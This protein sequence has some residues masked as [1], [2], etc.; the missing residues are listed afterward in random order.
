MNLNIIL[1]GSSPL[2]CYIQ[3]AYM[4]GE[5]ENLDVVDVDLSE[6]DIIP[7]PDKI[8]FVVTKGN[9]EI[10]QKS[11]LPFAENIQS[12]LE[13]K[14]LLSPNCCGENQPGNT[15]VDVLQLTDGRDAEKIRKQVQKKIEEIGK[16][17]TINHIAINNTGGTKTMSIYATLAVHNLCVNNSIDITEVYVDP[18][19]DKLR[20][21]VMKNRKAFEESMRSFPREI[22]KDLRNCVKLSIEE[23]VKLHFGMKCKITRDLKMNKAYDELKD[24]Y[25]KIYKEIAKRILADSKNIKE[26]EDEF[27]RILTC[28]KTKEN[29]DEDEKLQKY[30]QIEVPVWKEKAKGHDKLHNWWK[31]PGTEWETLW[32]PYAVERFRQ[33][34]KENEK[35]AEIMGVSDQT[36]DDEIKWILETFTEGFWLEA[37]CYEKIQDVVSQLA[38]EKKDM[39]DTAWSVEV[40]RGK[41]FEMDILVVYGYEL[42]LFSI[43]MAGDKENYLTKGKWFEANYRVEQ[44]AGEHGQANAVNFLTKNQKNFRK[45]LETFDNIGNM[46]ERIFDYTVFSKDG[47]FDEKILD[48]KIKALFE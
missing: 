20:C 6:R 5:R 3:A 42:T 47:K 34:C 1:V 21:R 40:K 27:S 44:I 14:G 2:P 11:T 48:E 16:E 23:L 46:S 15:G 32:T 36:K 29:Y 41:K 28:I 38:Q 17:S 26:Y 35:L 25:K 10:K 39:I 7:K 12:M 33:D 31:D 24:K 19:T 22:G 4:L 8:L 45:D 43:S 13:L 9:E 18:E 37:Y 30:F